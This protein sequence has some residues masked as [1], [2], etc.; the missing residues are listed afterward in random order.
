EINES[1][2]NILDAIV[3]VKVADEF[4]IWF[5][6]HIPAMERNNFNG[7]FYNNGWN[8]PIQVQTLPFDIAARDRGVTVWGLIG[9]GVL[10]YHLSV[11]DL[12]PPASSNVNG[13]DTYGAKLSN[14]RFSARAT[15]NLLDPENYY[16]TSGTYYGEQ[17]TL[18]IGF[19]V[20][21]QK[22]VEPLDPSVE[23]DNDLLAFAADLLFEKNLGSAGTFTVEGGYWNYE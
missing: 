9:G 19:V 21:S 14:A 12:H 16:Y 20:H 15:L 4:Q 22:G 2:V 17:D 7:P 13:V 10:K 5:G 11:V 8:L 23:L 1:S 18:A 3:Q 6:Q